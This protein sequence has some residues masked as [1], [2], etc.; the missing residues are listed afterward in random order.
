MST[1]L[2][3]S[4][5][6]REKLFQ[7]SLLLLVAS[8]TPELAAGILLMSLHHL[9]SIHVYFCIQIPLFIRTPVTLD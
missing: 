6:M 5:A 8:G 7:A 3:P 9:P 2:V 1:E 4:E